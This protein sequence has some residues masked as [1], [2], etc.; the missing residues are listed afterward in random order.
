MTKY[1]FELNGKFYRADA[2]TLAVLRSVMHAAK[3]GGDSSAVIAIMALGE[4]TG[5]IV[6]AP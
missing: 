5:R 6:E 4:R 1:T 3:A 2:E